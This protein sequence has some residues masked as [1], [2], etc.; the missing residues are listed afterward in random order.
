MTVLV[1]LHFQFQLVLFLFRKCF[2][3]GFRKLP[4]FVTNNWLTCVHIGTQEV[5]VDCLCTG[6]MDLV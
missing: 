2:S 1:Q 6:K 5:I 3:V 4:S